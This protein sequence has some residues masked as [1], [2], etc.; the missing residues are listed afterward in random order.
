MKNFLLTAAIALGSMAGAAD[1]AVIGTGDYTT[2]FNGTGGVPVTIFD[3]FD[4]V[5]S[6]TRAGDS[7]SAAFT[8]SSKHSDTFGGSDSSDVSD[9]AYEVGP[10]GGYYGILR[11]D[12]AQLVS[13]FAVQTYKFDGAAEQIRIYG[14][15]GLLA[16]FNV[17]TIPTLDITQFR[18]FFGT[19][20]E[21][22]A[23]VE[24]E[25]DFYS[26]AKLKYLFDEPAPVPVPA[27]GL[28][29]AGAV[30]GLAGMRRR[31]KA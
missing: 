9:S 17:A 28:M 22:F 8:L 18:G 26:M 3:F 25:G 2:F 31:R 15:S 24:L 7:Y 13:A 21:H 20:G 4:D 30:A 16:S 5:D 11:I 19:A 1:A 10:V 6:G 27:A 12:F 29:L 14:L 23:A